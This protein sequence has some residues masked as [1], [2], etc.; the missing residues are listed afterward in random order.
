MKGYLQEHLEAV[1]ERNRKL[2]QEDKK[3]FET[4]MFW[5]GWKTGEIKMMVEYLERGE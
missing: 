5:L 2:W 1:A 3:G 4:R